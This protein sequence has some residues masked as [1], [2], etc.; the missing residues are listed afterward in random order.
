MKKLISFFASSIAGLCLLAPAPAHAGLA[1]CGNINVEAESNC[2][3]KTGIECAADCT[4]ISVQAACSAELQVTCN[5]K[6]TAS[7]SVECSGSC[8]ADCVGECEVDPPKLD[9]KADCNLKA[10]AQC[11]GECSAAANK[12]QCAASCK[13]TFAAECD[14]SCTGKPPSATCQAKCQASCKG[15][16]Q[17]EA[18]AS[19]QVDCQTDAYA[20]CEAKIKGHCDVDCSS[21]GDGAVYCDGQYI[22]HGGNLQECINALKAINVQVEGSAEGSCSEGECHGSAEGSASCA[23][24]GPTNDAGGGVLLALGT[25]LGLGHLRRSRRRAGRG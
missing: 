10:D 11:Q 17:A 5:G 1:A 16:C 7:A 23:L 8:E 3:V 25:A 6:C 18:R 2:E 24:G 20:G 4:P 12:A 14:A 13:A 21:T 22:D 15:S 19:C 9:C